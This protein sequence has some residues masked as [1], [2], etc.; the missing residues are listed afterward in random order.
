MGVDLK[1][2]PGTLYTFRFSPSRII[3]AITW[4]KEMLAL[5]GFLLILMFSSPV[6]AEGGSNS[7]SN[8]LSKR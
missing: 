2:D 1:K 3:K 4:K 5:S 8:Y 7:P 6:F